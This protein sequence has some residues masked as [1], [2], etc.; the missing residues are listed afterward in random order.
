VFATDGQRAA[1]ARVIACIALAAC[2]P[3]NIT[4]DALVSVDAPLNFD[5]TC[6]S[7]A[8]PTTALDPITVSGVLQEVYSQDGMATQ[9]P[10]ADALIEG[11]NAAA[12]DC[13][14]ANSY[15]TTMSAADGTFTIGPVTTGGSP[16]ELFL[17][18]TKVGD[19]TTRLYFATPISFSQESG[20]RSSDYP[21]LQNAFV[22]QLAALGLAQDVNKSMLGIQ[23]LD[24]M[25]QPITDA[26]NVV[27]SIKQGGTEVT[28]TTVINAGKL[29]PVFGGG[30]FILNV[31]PGTVEVGA[32]HA[33]QS[34]LPR[35]LVLTAGTTSET[36]LRPG[37]H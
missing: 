18:V 19:R 23:L 12:S 10:L 14:D 8:A 21:I 26:A 9:R 27:L 35:T 16:F 5:F 25:N 24:C 7:K 11:C 4:T 36:Q 37:H 17:M 34:L 33:G 15:G 13:L 28:G 31:P 22:A 6:K 3:S 29:S 20:Q 2:D 1:L 32:T 30:Y